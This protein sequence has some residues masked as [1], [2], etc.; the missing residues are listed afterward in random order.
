MSGLLYRD[1]RSSI[2]F[3]AKPVI[4]NAKTAKT[5]AIMLVYCSDKNRPSEIRNERKERR[6]KSPLPRKNAKAFVIA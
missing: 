1:L 2:D 3:A 5:G 6:K 4:A